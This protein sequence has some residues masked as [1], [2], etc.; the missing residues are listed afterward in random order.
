MPILAVAS[1]GS[2]ND[3]N[4]LI[5]LRQAIEISF[6]FGIV[7]GGLV[8]LK[9]G[10]AFAAS[11]WLVARYFPHFVSVSTWQFRALLGVFLGALLGLLYLV[12][13]HEYEPILFCLYIFPAMVCGSLVTIKLLPILIA[14]PKFKHARKSESTNLGD[15]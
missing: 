15:K 4:N 9:F 3:F 5:I 6:L 14:S 13:S 11:S 8:A 7:I 2:L 12:A 10:L 1:M